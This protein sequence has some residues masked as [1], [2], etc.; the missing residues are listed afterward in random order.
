MIARIT[1]VVGL[2]TA[3]LAS[4]GQPNV[5]LVTLDGVR[6]QE[7][8]RGSDPVLDQ[9]NRVPVILPS[10]WQTL[11]P[12][13]VLLGN[14]D[15]GTGMEISNPDAISLPAYHSILSG[16]TPSCHSN[17]CGRMPHET[18]PERLVRE[19]A[20]PRLKVATISSW[21]SLIHI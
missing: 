8:F 12:Q 19:L 11:L 20:L 1:L 18:L 9:G 2:L 14:N 15:Q 16:L 21:L 7:V 3:T 6:W 4:A 13:G 5:I 17:E 10:L